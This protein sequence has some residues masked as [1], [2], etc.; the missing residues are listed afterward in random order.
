MD[1]LETQRRLAA[2]LREAVTGGSG[3]TDVSLRHA[4]LARA[5]GGAAIPE[6]YDALV[7]QIGEAAP[8]VTDRQVAA[9]RSTTGS[10]KASFEILLTASIGAGLARW[11]AATQAIEE[12][13]DAAR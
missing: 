11:D 2:A 6:P 10:D 12:A 7:R 4:A 1:A 3:E 9:V 8:G 13:G 5:A